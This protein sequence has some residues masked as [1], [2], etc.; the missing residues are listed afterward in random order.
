MLVL[1]FGFEP[2]APLSP[3]RPENHLERRFVYTGTHDH[4]TARGWYES[5]DR[6]RRRLAAR[7]GVSGPEPWWA[8]IRLAFSSPA[9]VAMVQVQD[10]LG[11]DS[12]AR[13]NDP[14]CPQ[15]R[16]NWRWRLREGQLTELL[17]ARLRAETEVAGRLES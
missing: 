16:R 12:E 14:G 3:H 17:A 1:Q 4:D 7:Y 2:H 15:R 6:P 10:I 8:L 11:L 5:L 9:R 13:I